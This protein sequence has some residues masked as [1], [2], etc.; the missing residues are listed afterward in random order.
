M[1][2]FKT[3]QYNIIWIL[4]INSSNRM[5]CSIHILLFLWQ[6]QKFKD[7]SLLSFRKKETF[8]CAIFGKICYVACTINR[9]GKL[10][11]LRAYFL[12]SK[13]YLNMSFICFPLFTK[14][15][16][17]IVIFNYDKSKIIME[18]VYISIILPWDN[19][20]KDNF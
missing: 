2:T 5:F 1:K 16:D 8:A 14:N 13:K 15:E 6:T 3:L 19:I 20:L 7:K 12:Q 11:R 4:N 18:V 9:A 10:I 17:V